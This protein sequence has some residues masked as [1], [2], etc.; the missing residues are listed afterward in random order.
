[1]EQRLPKK[2]LFQLPAKCTSLQT[3]FTEAEKFLAS[4]KNE[5]SNKRSKR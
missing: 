3:A 4:R 2:I 1:M 5:N